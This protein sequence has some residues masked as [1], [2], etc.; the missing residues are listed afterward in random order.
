MDMVVRWWLRSGYEVERKQ[1]KVL[2]FTVFDFWKLLFLGR[3][4]RKT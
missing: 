2:N 1:V 3:V 4:L